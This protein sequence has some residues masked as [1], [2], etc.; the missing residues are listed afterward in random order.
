MLVRQLFGKLQVQLAQ[1]MSHLIKDF[2]VGQL[3]SVGIRVINVFRLVIGMLFDALRKGVKQLPLV[4]RGGIPSR[5][6]T[7]IEIGGKV[8]FFV[9]SG[10]FHEIL[11][12]G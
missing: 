12:Y 8:E 4:I 3:T 5:K 9:A 10:G 2:L 6:P 11:R 1:G 7:V